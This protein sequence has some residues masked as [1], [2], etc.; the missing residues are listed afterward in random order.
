MD[1]DMQILEQLVELNTR[2]E[3]MTD[4]LQ[5]IASWLVLHIGVFVPGVI[6][7]G[8]MYWALHQFI[9]RYY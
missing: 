8:L 6:I 3:L 4:W 9:N 5:T 1:Y 7:L 2:V